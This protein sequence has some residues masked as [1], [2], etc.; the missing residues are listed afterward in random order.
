MKLI[1]VAVTILAALLL[2]GCFN[3][4]I[5]KAKKRVIRGGP[6]YEVAL[7]ELANCKSV[8]WS[9]F[10]DDRRRHFVK[11][12]CTL[13]PGTGAQE[14]GR[15]AAQQLI[16]NTA[17]QIKGQYD[18]ALT[19]LDRSINTRATWLGTQKPSESLASENASLDKDGLKLRDMQEG[20]GVFLAKVDAQKD[21]DLQVLEN[22]LGA[23]KTVLGEFLFSISEDSA[24]LTGLQVVLGDKTYEVPQFDAAGLVIAIATQNNA[25]QLKFWGQFLGQK[26]AAVENLQGLRLEM[27]KQ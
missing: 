19:E 23:G 14:K 5:S 17:V 16:E 7:T 20:K 11:A 10:E 4:D 24:E 2:Q 25:D 27:Q 22:R 12:S 1:Q 15:Q 3:D 8:K 6:T 21:A 9:S 18:R 13:D 26:S